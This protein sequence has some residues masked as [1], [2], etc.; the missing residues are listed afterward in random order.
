MNN[1]F[2]QSDDDCAF[3]S[4][5]VSTD[6]IMNKM[7]Q[8]HNKKPR[9]KQGRT[10]DLSDLWIALIFSFT[11]CANIFSAIVQPCQPG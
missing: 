9:V 1:D 5:A 2:H 7:K 8:Q 6:G 4:R 10:I 3:G 11:A